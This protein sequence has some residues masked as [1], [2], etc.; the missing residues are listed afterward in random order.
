MQVGR[1]G[2]QVEGVSYVHRILAVITPHNCGGEHDRAIVVSYVHEY[3]Y[4]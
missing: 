4:V 2:T 1:G 3:M